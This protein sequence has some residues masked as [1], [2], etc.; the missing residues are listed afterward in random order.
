MAGGRVCVGLQLRGA[1]WLARGLRARV[2]PLN[3]LSRVHA[4]KNRE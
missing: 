4:L 2:S 3:S 1:E